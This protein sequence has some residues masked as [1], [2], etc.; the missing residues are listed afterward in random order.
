MAGQAVP[1]EHSS[2]CGQSSLRGKTAYSQGGKTVDR[3][4]RTRTAHSTGSDSEQFLD[5]VS[6]PVKQQTLAVDADNSSENTVE[7][8]LE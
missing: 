8:F 7:F 3:P 1:T 4:P 2:D 6:S 5:T